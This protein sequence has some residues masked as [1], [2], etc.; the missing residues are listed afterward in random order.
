MKYG[1]LCYEYGRLKNTESVNL[2]DEIQSIAASCFL[3][4]I[5]CYIDRENIKSFAPTININNDK[6]KMIMNAWYQ[7]DAKQGPPC[8]VITPLLISIHINP[9]NKEFVD[10]LFYS[11]N[12]EYLKQ[13][14]PIGARD[15]NTM[16][17]LEKH[18]IKAYFSGCLTLTL[19]KNDRIV[20][21][22]YILCV[23]VSDE[24]IAVLRKN[25]RKKIYCISPQLPNNC[26]FDI[27]YK[28]NLAFKLLDAYQ[29]ASC[30]ITSR[31]H[32]AMPSLALETP[33]LLINDNKNEYR[34]GGLENFVR[35]MST[36]EY[37]KNLDFFNINNPTENSDLYKSF[38]DKLILSC[39]E[40]TGYKHRDISPLRDYSMEEAN[41]LQ[42]IGLS[43]LVEKTETKNYLSWYW[44]RKIDK[45]KR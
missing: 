14:Q 30:I 34:F 16:Q 31:L 18:G 37:L 38:R 8:D 17:L 1:L 11:K 35:H 29:S 9:S 10:N 24:L 42:F 36:Q 20:K 41:I 4:R 26:F 39:E 22:D 3:P 45:L 25:T 27:Q 44:K 32:C 7:H 28:Y 43:K 23:D 19:P 13:Y 33:V 6:I 21:Q 5:D 40:F 15:L 2:G 12:I